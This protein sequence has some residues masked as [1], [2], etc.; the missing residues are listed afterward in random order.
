MAAF[1]YFRHA[2]ANVRLVWVFQVGGHANPNVV[3][4]I[5]RDGMKGGIVVHDQV[6]P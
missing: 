6:P 1:G 5:V 4:N 3:R 2:K